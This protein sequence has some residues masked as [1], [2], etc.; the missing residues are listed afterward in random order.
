MLVRIFTILIFLTPI[1]SIQAQDFWAFV[2]QQ[3]DGGLDSWM[4]DNHVP[5]ISIYIGLPESLDTTFVYGYADK[6]NQV[7][8]E[9]DMQFQLGSMTTAMVSFVILKLVDNGQL[10]LDADVNT[11]LKSW[12]VPENKWTKQNPLTIRDLLT[13]QRGFET[14]S[15]PKGYADPSNVPT[16]IEIL[17]GDKKSNM[18]ALKFKSDENK[19]GNSSFYCALILQLILE[20]H[21]GETLTTIMEREAIDPMGLENSQF[22]LQYPENTKELVV[23]YDKKGNRIEND[24]WVYPEVAC[25]G[26]WSNPADYGKFVRILQSAALGE[27][28]DLISADLALQGFGPEIDNGKS[29]IFWKNGGVEVGWG[30]ASQGFRTQMSTNMADKRLIVAM[31]NSWENWQFMAQLTDLAHQFID[32]LKND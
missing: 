8:L 16:V 22:V 12:K 23:G 9:D 28:K 4:A 14:I 24:R 20:D 29:L 15:K 5:G 10:A 25:A 13:Y 27:D 19:S 2:D 21:F 7:I 3:V 31:M 1:W 30:G 32:Q 11:Y 26:L 6:E 17:N 18:P